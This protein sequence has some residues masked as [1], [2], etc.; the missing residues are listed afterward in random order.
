MA[1]LITMIAVTVYA[2]VITVFHMK[3][4]DRVRSLEEKNKNQ[5]KRIKQLMLEKKYAQW[6]LE[7]ASTN[8]S[9]DKDKWFREKQRLLA[10]NDRLMERLKRSIPG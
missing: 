2:F 3:L 8:K 1:L 5:A 6:K 9:R 7:E 10:I 4:T